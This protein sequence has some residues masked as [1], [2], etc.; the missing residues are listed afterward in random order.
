MKRIPLFGRASL[1]FGALVLSLSLAQA[2]NATL[3]VQGVLKN[4]DGSTVPDGDTYT[5]TFKLWNELTGGSVAWQETK[6][7]VSIIGGI[8]SVVLGDGATV[9]NA[10]FDRPYYLGISLGTGSGEEFIPRPRLASAP[11]ALSLLGSSNIFPSTGNVG[12]GTTTPHASALL[13]AQA[14]NK[15]VLFPRMTKAQ[16]DAIASPATGLLLFQT[17]EAPG[18]YYYTGSAWQSVN[19]FTSN[20]T[21][22]IG[23]SYAGGIIFYLEPSGLNGLVAAP[24]S[25]ESTNVYLWG[26]S[27]TAIPSTRG[28]SIGSGL[29]NTSSSVAA[30]E[31]GATTTAAE[32]ADRLVINGCSDWYLP[33]KDE[34]NLMH[35]NLHLAGLGGF[36]LNTNYWSSTESDATEAWKMQFTDDSATLPT[37][38]PKVIN[39]RVRVIRAF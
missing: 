33:S 19:E 30:C 15:G 4:S 39:Y 23:D 37:L 22:H 1:V 26:C 10:P 20:T 32:R 28:S 9:L 14:T 34:I 3:A 36:T 11:Y 25:S 24:A 21:L 6:T 27:G 31:M 13:E 12:V 2:Q 35:K 7:N 38:A 16:R 29:A 18:F 17:D 5:I 8:Y